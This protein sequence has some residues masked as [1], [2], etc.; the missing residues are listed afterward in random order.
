MSK[1]G[2]NNFPDK[3][4]WGVS[5]SSYQ[6]EGA[7]YEDG[8]G[9]SIWDEFCKKPGAIWNAHE[10]DIAC[11]HYHLY[12]DDIR[13]MKELGVKAYRF[14]LSWAR[15]LPDGIGKINQKGIEFYNRL[16]DEVILAGIEPHLTLYHWD[17]PLELSK[18]GGWA[19]RGCIEWFAEYTRVAVNAFSDR[20][21][22]W[23][24]VN[25]PQ[26]IISL[27]YLQGAHAPGLKLSLK[28]ALQAGHYL[29]MASGKA[30]KIIREE[31]KQ[32]VK[33]GLAV[34]TQIRV[35]ASDKPEDIEAAKVAMH[36]VEPDNLWNNSWWMDP[37]Y[38]GHYPQAGLKAYAGHLPQIEPEDMKLIHQ[39]LDFCCN[40]VYTGK[41]VKAGKDGVSV[42]VAPA[43]G[44][45]ITMQE[46]WEVIPE[47]I[48][49]VSKWM[50]ERYKL[51][52]MITENGHQNL[53]FVHMDGQVH[54]PQRID[55]IHRHLLQLKKAMDE[56]T[57]VEGYFAW[58]LLDNFEWSWGYRVRVGMVFTDF[59]TLERIPKD[60]YYW[61]Q[62]W[63]KGF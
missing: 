18:K 58:T 49:W 23:Y 30:T 36:G 37:V 57:P 22:Y 52:I 21:K 34:A 48:Y 26:C 9:L 42:I 14:S 20:V 8:K 55:Y 27:G 61:Y 24:P 10:G 40:N 29:L 28:E 19:N 3:F 25:E 1:A 39:P 53:D 47:T 33:I 32:K 43:A 63:I 17:L 54:D 35:P 62:K 15:I 31:A 13:L 6:I 59:Q 38:L 16:I 11:D 4:V 50:H 5:T 56:G 46:D 12:K 60:S 41:R 44:Y 45:N 51:P 7:A 2:P